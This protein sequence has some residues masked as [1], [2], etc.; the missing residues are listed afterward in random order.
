MGPVVVHGAKGEGSVLRA[1][2]RVIPMSPVVDATSPSTRDDAVTAA[3][4]AVRAGQL[5][6]IPTDTVYGIGCDAFSREGVAMVLGAKGRGREMPPPVL[7]GDLRVLDGLARDVPTWVRD[8][9]AEA[10][11]GPLTVIL[12]AQLSLVWDLGETRGTVA[13]RMPDDEIALAVLTEVGPMAVTSANLTGQPPARTVLDAATQLGAAVSVYV[14]GGP[15]QDIQPSTIVDC[16]GDAPVV[17]R[18][19]AF[20]SERVH[21]VYE[22]ALATQEPPATEVPEAT[23]SPEPAEAAPTAHPETPGTT[24][25][26]EP[27]ATTTDES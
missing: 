6:V 24:P 14:D 12:H 26:P 4:E 16:T 22:A 5:V 7:V 25:S 1:R 13:L 9:L 8:L 19:G 17:L 11:P 15:R 21:E 2:H 20:P 27:T 18:E 10:W 23:A 3:I